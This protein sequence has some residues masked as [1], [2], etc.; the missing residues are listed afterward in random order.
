MRETEWSTLG[1]SCLL[2]Q[3]AK[4]LIGVV[5]HIFPIYFL[6]KLNLFLSTRSSI[7]ATCL[8]NTYKR[9]HAERERREKRRE[10]KREREKA[11]T[12]TCKT[13]KEHR[14]HKILTP[15]KPH[16]TRAYIHTGRP[17]NPQEETKSSLTWLSSPPLGELDEARV[18]RETVF[19][20]GRVRHVR[21]EVARQR[22]ELTGDESLLKPTK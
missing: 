14:P 22:G 12:Q 18:V 16:K 9:L 20:R 19:S 13:L 2:Q 21:P 4:K 5:V 3:Q 1:L 6:F 17:T 7:I 15:H 8:R 11:Q 10:G